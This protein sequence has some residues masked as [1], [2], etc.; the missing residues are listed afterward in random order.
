[1]LFALRNDNH[2]KFDTR[3][4]EIFIVNGAIHHLMTSWRVYK[5]R[6]RESEKL[7]TVL[8]LYNLEIHQ[9]KAK[10]DCHR[11]KTMVKRSF[12]QDLRSRN[13]EARNGRIEPNILVRNQREQR[14]RRLLAM[15]RLRAVFERRPRRKHKV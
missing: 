4:D 13:F 3:F 2:Q 14:T 9:K 11:L 7:K 5:I 15:A 8:A 6:K 1:M 10:P 12:D